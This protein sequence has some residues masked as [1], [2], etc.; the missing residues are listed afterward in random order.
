MYIGPS[1]EDPP[2]PR[3]P[4]KRKA[5]SEQRADDGAAQRAGDGEAERALREMEGVGERASRAGDDRRIESKQQAAECGDHGAANNMGIQF[6]RLSTG[7]GG[8]SKTDFTLS[9]T[10]ARLIP[11]GDGRG[12]DAGTNAGRAWGERGASVER[13]WGERADGWALTSRR[14]MPWARA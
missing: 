9:K 11:R 6:H 8:R 3:P 13:A 1:T 7:M 2:M 14:R 12:A 5:T 10:G 4:M